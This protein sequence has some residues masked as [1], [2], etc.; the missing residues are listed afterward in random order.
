MKELIDKVP[1]DQVDPELVD[2]YRDVISEFNALYHLEE[3]KEK[4][5]HPEGYA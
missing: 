4:N 5:N 2:N 3:A 1:S